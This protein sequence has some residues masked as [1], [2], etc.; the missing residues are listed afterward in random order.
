[1]DAAQAANGWAQKA[2]KKQ[3]QKE[4]AEEHGKLGAREYAYNRRRNRV[5]T[6]Y[7]LRLLH[8]W[9]RHRIAPPSRHTDPHSPVIIA[10]NMIGCAMYEL[11]CGI[12]TS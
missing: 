3:E 8:L 10:E 9:V 5:L 2:E 6:I 11:V 7:R 12:E 4:E 1:V